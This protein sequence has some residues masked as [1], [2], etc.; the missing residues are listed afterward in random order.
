MADKVAALETLVESMQE[1]LQLNARTIRV[2]NQDQEDLRDR[3]EELEIVN[4][5][6]ISEI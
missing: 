5:N 4:E 6:L 2:M 1:Q 3:L